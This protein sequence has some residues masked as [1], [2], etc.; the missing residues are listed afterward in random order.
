MRHGARLTGESPRTGRVMQKHRELVLKP[1][2]NT[3]QR[4]ACAAGLRHTVFAAEQ[5]LTRHG[6]DVHGLIGR[7][8]I[9]AITVAGKVGRVAGMARYI[10]IYDALRNNPL[11]VNLHP[12]HT[13]RQLRRLRP[14]RSAYHPHVQHAVGVVGIQMIGRDIDYDALAFFHNRLM[15][16]PTTALHVDHDALPLSGR[17]RRSQHAFHAVVIAVPWLNA[18]QVLA[19]AVRLNLT[20]HNAR[21]TLGG[22]IH[23][24]VKQ[25]AV[26]DGIAQRVLLVC[27]QTVIHLKGINETVTLSHAVP[28]QGFRQ[29]VFQPRGHLV[30]A[31]ASLAEIKAAHPLQVAFYSRHAEGTLRKALLVH[32]VQPSQQRVGPLVDTHPVDPHHGMTGLTVVSPCLPVCFR[33]V[34]VIIHHGEHVAPDLVLVK[35]KCRRSHVRKRLHCNM[36]WLRAFTASCQQQYQRQERD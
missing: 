34:M 13:A 12:F 2:D 26:A 24:N 27:I 18:M 7:P 9:N 30:D 33:C 8:L 22:Q 19:Q 29:P 4:V 35:Y 5:H 15:A 25:L 10:S 17:D 28:E 20:E 1:E 14:Q 23:R 3:P 21:E 11:G 36:S 31:V 32:L 6:T 16:P